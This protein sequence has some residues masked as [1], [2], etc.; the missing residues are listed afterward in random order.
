MLSEILCYELPSNKPSL[1]GNRHCNEKATFSRDWPT[2]FSIVSLS[3]CLP[4]AN[5]LSILLNLIMAGECH[6]I[7]IRSNWR[8]SVDDATK[9]YRMITCV[10]TYS[11]TE[12]FFTCLLTISLN[13]SK[14]KYILPLYMLISGV[15]NPWYKSLKI[16]PHKREDARL[17][18]RNSFANV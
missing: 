10:K 11:L 4:P 6:K 1:S 14:R 9:S 2:L 12:R 18:R 8:R 5:Q 16:S 15:F 3:A 17:S 7:Y 13:V